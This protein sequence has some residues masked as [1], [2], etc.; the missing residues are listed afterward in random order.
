[1]KLQPRHRRSRWGAK[2]PL[3]PPIEMPP[4]IK[5]TTTNP[6]VFSVFFLAFLLIQQYTSTTD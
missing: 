1:M 4:M 5:T 2:S 6:Y 3:P